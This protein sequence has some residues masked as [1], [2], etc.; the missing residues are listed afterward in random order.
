MPLSQAAFVKSS[1]AMSHLPQTTHTHTHTHTHTCMHACMH[2]H[3]QTQAHNIPE[4]AFVGLSNVGKSSMV[5]MLA[6][7]DGEELAKVSRKPGVGGR[8]ERGR[9]WEEKE[10]F[11]LSQLSTSPNPHP[12]C[13][14][15]KTT[16]LNH[17]LINRKW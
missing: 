6:G 3:M 9:F 2:T 15:G 16:T 1:S 13:V 17:F 14:L 5:N 8:G 12:C 4:F 11:S 10:R 7:K